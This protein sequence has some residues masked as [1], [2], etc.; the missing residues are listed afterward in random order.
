M[1]QLQS[2]RPEVI[3]SDIKMPD[4]DGLELLKKIQEHDA[5]I[6]VVIMTGYGTID[7]AVRGIERWRLRFS[8]KALRQRPYRPGDPQRP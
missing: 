3:L 6:S 1:E 5:A 4:L 7:M 2:C 8:A